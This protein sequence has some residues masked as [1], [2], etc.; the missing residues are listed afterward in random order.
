M[1][2][3]LQYDFSEPR[4]VFHGRRLPETGFP[5]GYAALIDAHD[6]KVPLPRRLSAIG[7]HHRTIQRDGW[8]I[9][10]PRRAPDP[11]FEGHLTFALKYEGLDLAVLK[12]L[13]EGAGAER[14]EAI[15]RSKPTGTYSRRIWF[16]YEWLLGQELNLS[17][18]KTGRYV[19][20]VD[21]DQQ[22]EGRG[23]TVSRQR[24]RNNLP[25]TPEFCPLVYRTDA[26]DEFIAMDLP[27]RA[28]AAMADVPRDVLARTASFLLL[29][30]SKS[31]FAIEGEQPPQARL[32]G[33]A[34][35]IGEAGRNLTDFEE[36]LRL[37]N[38]VIG[39]TRFVHIGLRIEGGFVGEH[40]RATRMPL[41]E[42]ISAR[43]EDLPSLVDGMTAFEQGPGGDL[44]PVVEAATLS[45][46]FVYAHPFEDGN[47]RVHRYLIHHV[48]SKRGFNPA[49]MVFPVSAAILERI[50]EYRAVLESYSKRLLPLIEWMPTED[51]NV[52]VVNDTGD[53]YRFFDATP[54]TEFIYSCVLQTIEHDLPEEARFL[55]RYD[56]FCAGVGAIVDMPARTLDLLFRF[57][58]QNDGTLSGRARSKEFAALTAR[59]VD[60][61]ER[62]YAD[63][64]DAD[65]SAE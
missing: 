39:D 15:V 27:E 4:T 36:L 19:P 24:V 60:Q 12:R 56:A 30:D 5:V 34:R 65:L 7:E 1:N 6:L 26:L 32:Q 48:L 28:Q 2:Q 37:Q 10:T 25:G 40:D 61:I 3:P 49:G 31:S 47:G 16:L 9:H 45:F 62:L 8:K 38:I 20:V 18:A 14:V 23:E 55:Q 35:A 17:D 41:P 33:W 53:F 58:Q 42:H 57:L 59:E 22:Y 11:S 13:F 46:G 50:D 51:G 29:K 52:R 44:D 63:A 21:P 64:F 43:P 54:Q